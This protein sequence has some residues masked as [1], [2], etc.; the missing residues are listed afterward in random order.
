MESDYKDA[1]KMVGE[2][3]YW[4][5][6]KRTINGRPMAD[7][8]IAMIINAI[9]DGLYLHS[10]GQDNLLDIGCGN[11]ALTSMLYPSLASMLGIDYSEYLISVAKRDFEDPGHFEY[12]VVAAE[13]YIETAEDVLRFNKILMYGC[14][15][16]F[17][18]AGGVL[19]TLRKRFSNVERIFLGNLPDLAKA[20][21]FYYGE[22]PPWGELRNFD[23]KIGI[24][25]TEAEIS[26]L[27]AEAGWSASFSYMPSGFY[28]S[29]YRYDVVLT[30]V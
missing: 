15:A 1:A 27:S 7:S 14:F 20:E 13:E 5:Q 18:D 17:A 23:S 12:R 26:T 10:G 19:R 30:P 16:Y 3:D 4:A 8:D 9:S 28:A 25:R 29:H 2:K 24:W 6:V 11:G 22:I 21:D